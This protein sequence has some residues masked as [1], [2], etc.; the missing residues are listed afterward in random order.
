[1]I[2]LDS[3]NVHLAPAR[4]KQL[5]SRLR[6]SN[7]LGER[8]GNFLLEIRL[9]RSGKALDLRVAVR[10]SAGSF[11]VHTRQS[12]WDD[13]CHALSRLISRRLHAQAVVRAAAR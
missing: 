3:G 11:D 7:R 6:R 2:K 9:K 8:L 4:R 10:D 12:T 1:M 13:A 5:M